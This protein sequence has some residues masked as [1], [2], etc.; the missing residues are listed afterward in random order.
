MRPVHRAR[1]RSFEVDAF[2]VITA[3]VTRALEFVLARLPI[4][5]AAQVSAARIDYEKTIGRAVYPDTIF[6]LKLCINTEREVRG[7]ADLERSIGFKQC[8]RQEK[9][10]ERRNHA[11]RNAATALQT[12]RLR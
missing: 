4:R 2:I 10:K 12:K 11:P 9:A 1:R 5:C 7:I 6:L 8:A 3:A